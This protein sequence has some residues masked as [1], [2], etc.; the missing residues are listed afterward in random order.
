MTAQ[1]QEILLHKGEKLSLFSLPLSRYMQ[2]QGQ[3]IRFD[4]GH[5]ACHRGYLG[6]WAVREDHLYLVEIK[7]RI[8]SR[9]VALQD[10]FPGH[11]AGVFAHWYSG[12]ARCPQ[13]KRVQYVHQGFQSVHE[14][15][16]FL[17][18]RQGVL[19]GERRVRND[20]FEIPHRVQKHT[21]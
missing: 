21:D 13:G 18:F 6:T 19:V 14:E 10:I 15:D 5:T 9:D 11:S 8:G 2:Q 3:P 7:A 16:L 1:F 20:D 12:T 4:L 17:T